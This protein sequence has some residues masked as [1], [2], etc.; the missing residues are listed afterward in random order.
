[1][2]TQ[3]NTLSTDVAPH[4]EAPFPCQH[5]T[6]R[7]EP[8]AYPALQ[9][10]PGH[11]CHECEAWRAGGIRFV[12][13]HIPWMRRAQTAALLFHCT[14]F[15]TMSFAF[16]VACA[17]PVLWPLVVPYLLWLTLST[18]AIDGSL[19][20]R[21]EWMRSLGLW[22]LVAD[23]YPMKL[24]KTHELPPD[25]KYIMGYHPHGIISHGA[26]CAFATDVLGFA[27]KFPGITNSLLTLE[28]NFRIPIYRD[29]ILGM[30]VRSVSKESICN[31]LSKG[32]PDGSGQG[33][34]VTIVVG[35]A[36]ESLEARPGKMKLVLKDRKGFVKLALRTGADL[37]PVI[38]FGEN[39]LYDQLCSKSHPFVYGLQQLVLK[40]FKFTI[41]ALHGRG[42]LN[43]DYGLMPYRRPVNIVVGKPIQVDRAY[44]KEVP[45]E[46]ID[47]Y[48][49]LYL[50]ELKRVFEA[51]KAPF[52]HGPIPELQIL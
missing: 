51:Y 45:H 52:S 10:I 20:G 48:H 29:W 24:H 42:L 2:K 43:Y 17:V 19:A 40:I 34:A 31:I 37:V 35:G 8:R 32:G 4:H 26:W 28:S 41:P 36:R 11:G 47:R 46:V 49:Q 9:D 6:M 44:G 7:L 15:M 5:A 27:Q 23:Y 22:K 16:I 14:A 33:R 30:G 18:N 39:D 38:G 50:E 12:P 3:S 21:F 25:R 1:M 13:L